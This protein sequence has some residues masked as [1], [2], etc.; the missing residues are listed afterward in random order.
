MT[1]PTSLSEAI[2]AITELQVRA[3][4]LQGQSNLLLGFIVANPQNL[5]SFANFAKDVAAGT[6]PTDQEMRSVAQRLLSDGLALHA[7][8]QA[9]TPPTGGNPSG[10]CSNVGQFP[11]RP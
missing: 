11:S 10:S 4:W 6:N 9:P 1:I 8:P 3:E 2:S 7:S 5:Q